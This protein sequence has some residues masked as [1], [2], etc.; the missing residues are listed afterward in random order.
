MND[1]LLL[2]V[3]IAGVLGP[4]VVVPWITYV[5]GTWIS[6]LIHHGSWRNASSQALEANLSSAP[7]RTVD[8]DSAS[9]QMALDEWGTKIINT[10]DEVSMCAFE[11]LFQIDPPVAGVSE[12]TTIEGEALFTPGRRCM[13]IIDK[14]QITVLD[15]IKQ[16]GVQLGS[17]HS[18]KLGFVVR[19]TTLQG[20]TL[21]M[22]IL[23]D[24]EYF[25]TTAT[26]RRDRYL[27]EIYSVDLHAEQ[28]SALLPPGWPGKA[29]L[30]PQPDAPSVM[31]SR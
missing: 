30:L 17:D 15:R 25:D 6:N 21:T 1:I 4:L 16:H 28:A 5:I 9:Y 19:R 23:I 26:R 22:L 20:S 14:D 31:E 27:E 12:V 24:T 29:V 8:P 3:D 18:V 2:L 7:W 13:V 10:G 11:L